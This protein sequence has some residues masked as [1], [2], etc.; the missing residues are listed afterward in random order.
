MVC[1]TYAFILLRNRIPLDEVRTAVRQLAA[2]CIAADGTA[3]DPLPQDEA[4]AQ[5]ESARAHR[6][7]LRATTIADRLRVTV[8][9]GTDLGWPAQASERNEP[10]AP[11][12][13]DAHPTREYIAARGDD[14]RSVIRAYVERRGGTPPKLRELRDV[15][16]AVGLEA[17]E[18]TLA[19]DL[20]RIGVR[21]PRSAADNRARQVPL[22]VLNDPARL[23]GGA[24]RGVLS[25][26]TTEGEQ[27]APK[28]V[29]PSSVPFPSVPEREQATAPGRDAPASEDD[30]MK[31]ARA[32]VTTHET[33][34]AS[35]C[36]TPVPVEV[37]DRLDSERRRQAEAARRADRARTRKQEPQA[38]EQAARRQLPL[39]AGG[40]TR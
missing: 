28:G 40:A 17:S 34:P 26:G 3:S 19:K 32:P 27:I 14:R 35:T 12:D 29:D 11:A 18:R 8:E 2:E 13:L 33:A 16:A 4:D 15:L 39:A 21:N 6:M 1:W 9:E 23:K 30:H 22:P 31:T 5:V 38:A 24:N 37:L 7:P 20:R 25:S 36:A 10:E